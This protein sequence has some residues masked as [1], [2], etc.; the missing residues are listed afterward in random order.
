MDSRN[1]ISFLHRIHGANYS[2]RKS[3]LANENFYG[4]G[5]T[6]ANAQIFVG[7][8]AINC[9][10]RNADV[11]G[12]PTNESRGSRQTNRAEYTMRAKVQRLAITMT[13]IR[14]KAHTRRRIILTFLFFNLLF[15]AAVGWLVAR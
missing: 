7:S 5:T 10:A 3:F 8:G 14:R 9:Y 4:A 13:S 11:S 1:A 12:Q 6:D 2:E 15:W